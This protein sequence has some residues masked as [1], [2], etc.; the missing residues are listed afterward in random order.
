M[1]VK[2]RLYMPQAV[3]SVFAKP[4]LGRVIKK[5]LKLGTDESNQRKPMITDE[6][7]RIKRILKRLKSVRD[8]YM[9][10]SIG[11][12]TERQTHAADQYGWMSR[13]IDEAIRIIKES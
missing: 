11:Y 2:L 13:T 7:I 1:T 12:R 5:Q 9:K 4:F 8:S 6:Q 3:R 10:V